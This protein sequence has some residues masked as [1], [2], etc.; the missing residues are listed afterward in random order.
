MQETMPPLSLY[1]RGSTTFRDLGWKVVRLELPGNLSLGAFIAP[2][3]SCEVGHSKAKLSPSKPAE[4]LSPKRLGIIKF[5]K[6]VKN[7]IHLATVLF[8]IWSGS[9]LWIN[10][11]MIC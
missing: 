3:S 2:T 1:T 4:N 11:F 8:V 9:I 10:L 5:P 6:S 7:A